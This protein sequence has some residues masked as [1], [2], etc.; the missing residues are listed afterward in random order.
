MYYIGYMRLFAYSG[1]QR[2]LCYVFALF[3]LVLCTL[4]CRFLWIV[5]FDYPFGIL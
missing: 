2:I 5:P 3:V 4:C 1:V